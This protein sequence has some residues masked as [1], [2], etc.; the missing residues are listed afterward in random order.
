MAQLNGIRRDSLEQVS[1]TKK[2]GEEAGANIVQSTFDE[3]NADETYA[4]LQAAKEEGAA[5]IAAA[6]A[7]STEQAGTAQNQQGTQQVQIGQTMMAAAGVMAAS[8]LGALASVGTFAAGA[9]MVATG[10]GNQAQGDQKVAEAPPMVAQAADHS[11]Q[12]ANHLNK[13]EQ[14]KSENESQQANNEDSSDPNSAKETGQETEKD[15]GYYVADAGNAGASSDSDGGENELV[16][17]RLNAGEEAVNEQLGITTASATEDRTTATNESP[18]ASQLK[19]RTGE[20]NNLLGVERG[21]V[22]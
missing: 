4:R 10:Q 20:I 16:A 19:S 14:I 11:N 1:N 17:N 15:K 8:G 5:N 18:L 21:E 6:R 22:A 9:L 12:S 13:A 2:L 3:T 7:A